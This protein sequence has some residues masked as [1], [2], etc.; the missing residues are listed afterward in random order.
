MKN[1][2]RTVTIFI[3]LFLSACSPLTQIELATQDQESGVTIATLQPSPVVPKSEVTAEVDKSKS[4]FEPAIIVNDEGGPV[5]ITGEWNYASFLVTQ[6]FPE[7]VV[8]L[9]DVSAYIQGNHNEWVPRTS[10][11]LGTLTSPISPS[12]ASYQVVIPILPLGKSVDLDNDD[13]VDHGVQVLA[14]HIGPNLTGDSYLEQ[15]EQAGYDSY[16]T[17]PQ[18]GYINEGTFLVF[19]PDDEQG[20][21]NGVGEDGQIFTTDDP[22]V[23]IPAGYTL[24]HIDKDGEVS[25]NR[26]RTA[27]IDTLEE[28][29]Q[30]SPDF[31][32]Q[33][34]L[35]SYNS[36]IDLLTIRYSYTELRN[37]DWEQIRQNYLPLV[38]AADES[39]DLTAYYLILNDLALSI[40]DAHVYVSAADRE[41]RSA[42]IQKIFKEYNGSL[43][44][45]GVELS[46]GRYII[47]YVDPEGPGAQAGWEFGT[48]I[49]SVNGIPMRE[50][51][52]ELPL[53]E[54]RGSPETIRL[55]QA[56]FALAFPASS[57]VN[58]EYLQ[59]GE[60]QLLTSSMTAGEGYS[61]RAP[62]SAQ[63][64]GEISYK[65]LEGGFGYIHWSE[66]RDPL[67]VLTI[68]EK[69]LDEF[70][71]A[72]GIIIDLRNNIGGNAEL[73]YTMASYFFNSE[74]PAPYYWLDYY[75]YDE[76]V[77]DLVKQFPYAYPLSSPSPE[78]SFPGAVVILV[79]EGSASA[80]EYFPQ[81][82]QKQGRAI[83]V[84]EHGTDGAGGFIEQAT[85]PGGITFTFTKGRSYFAG[86][87]ELN[88]EAKGV[89]L[90]V[91]VPITEENEQAKLEGRDPVLE[92]ALN[93][94]S[95]EA[96]RYAV[97]NLTGSTWQLTQEISSS[98]GLTPIES[99][100]SY[101]IT[102]NED[103]TMAIKADCN[104]VIAEYSFGSAGKITINLGPT[105]LAL[106]PT[107]SISEDF[108]K[109]LAAST[110][111]QLDKQ[112]L[113]ILTD[114]QSGAVGLLFEA[115]E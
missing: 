79:N 54:S 40:R 103:G 58:I 10:Q 15:L 52:D 82:L 27:K 43:G 59:P 51:I 37:L 115:V 109:W 72:P 19:A 29:S 95:E 98:G 30:A 26:S 45:Q 2:L 70:H 35:E 63:E 87:D 114:P 92:T 57:E 89:E 28:T 66:F 94:L 67:Y 60:T 13:E 32:N 108:L 100:N 93:V 34:I 25:F 31:S 36:L 22:V 99:P 113:I 53:T 84:G 6:H 20:F 62:F 46:D 50:W 71:S 16:L 61:T 55:N 96:I 101:V 110:S 42:P 3:F 14:V 47:T 68:W 23:A 65:D 8:A 88:L 56:Q 4:S 97:K 112:G 12:P 49:V 48:E 44:A 73:M 18:T 111:F 7:P 85:L 74:K 78:I 69:F 80:A 39:G 102:F 91:R 105:T 5:L 76:V 77:N 81:F 38:Q 21:P 64:P 106:C 83:V 104:Q 107:G 86:T 33:G 11:V 41:L 90:D 1:I 24:V 75:T 9:M 17:D